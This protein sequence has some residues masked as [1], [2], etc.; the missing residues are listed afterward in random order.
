[1]QE[2]FQLALFRTSKGANLFA[3]RVFDLFDL[4]RNGVIEFG[5]FVRSFSTF[6]PKAPEKDK[7][8]CTHAWKTI[9]LYFVFAVDSS[10]CPKKLLSFSLQL[11]SN[12]TI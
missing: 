8:A 5:E 7:T 11:H 9:F 1:V 10:T 12:C 3:D 4:K 2:E 6:H